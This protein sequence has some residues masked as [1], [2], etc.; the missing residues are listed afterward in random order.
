[1]TQQNRH[2]P[3][4]DSILD[5]IRGELT[6]A[7]SG[8]L[9][10]KLAADPA[11]RLERDRLRSML[12]REQAAQHAALDATLDAK[13]ADRMAARILDRVRRDEDRPVI[14][15]GRR[16]LW[17][18][19]LAAS[20][21]VHVLALGVL[22]WRHFRAPERAR[23]AGSGESI[24]FAPSNGPDGD[25]ADGMLDGG[26]DGG[27]QPGIESKVPGRYV[28][29]D[30]RLPIDEVLPPDSIPSPSSASDRPIALY[31]REL[32]RAFG[33]R[34]NDSMKRLLD[35]RLGATGSLDRVKA[36]LA[37]FAHLPA[38]DGAFVDADGQPS[39][40]STA[41][42]ML[43][44]L[45]DGQSSRNGEHRDVVERGI[46][47]LFDRA[48]D[49]RAPL[50]DRSLALFALSEDLILS[51]GSL[52]PAESR[53]RRV[54]MLSLAMA[55]RDEARE[56][57]RAPAAGPDAAKSADARW[58]ELALVAA[59]RAGILESST[60]AA[61]VVLVDVGAIRAGDDVRTAMLD[62]TSLLKDRRGMAFTAW[63]TATA[64][65]LSA[66]LGADGLVTGTA[67]PRA[68]AE[69]TALVLLAL[70]VAYRTY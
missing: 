54:S 4:S 53:L 20:V 48:G 39:L 5:S 56:G 42:V 51:G 46:G 45:G 8:A 3:L 40:R 70:Q 55:V 33:I 31:P 16:R 61:S 28:V 15:P 66:R 65:T 36:G 57:R 59:A 23:D 30:E 27:V 34:R 9:A 67:A 38:E 49:A 29:D 14:V 19:L 6:S 47:W 2:N 13:A 37:A 22:S 26:A 52:T 10:A 25:A 58:T 18:R 50:G 63:N 7:E 43:A 69:E 32:G 60:L 1:M 62:G 17:I 68:R 35:S 44:F 64:R 21:A 12:V 11:L 41:T 24:A